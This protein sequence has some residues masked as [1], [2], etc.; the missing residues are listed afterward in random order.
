M[1][2]YALRAFLSAAVASTLLMAACPAAFGDGRIYMEFSESELPTHMMGA[3]GM[4]IDMWMVPSPSMFMFALGDERAIL[5]TAMAPAGMWI[6]AGETCGFSVSGMLAACGGDPGTYQWIETGASFSLLGVQ[7]PVTFFPEQG[8][9][10][11]RYAANGMAFTATIDNIV[12]EARGPWSFTGINLIIDISGLE[13]REPLPCAEADLGFSLVQPTDS[14]H[15]FSGI[16]PEPATLV[17][18]ALGGL[19]VLLRR[20][21]K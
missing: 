9:V 10:S 16:S 17:L 3:G 1:K 21:R 11:A 20:R 7:G 18:L 6:Q 4:G 13:V 8:M 14:G 5:L 12:M 2:T 15:A 19:G